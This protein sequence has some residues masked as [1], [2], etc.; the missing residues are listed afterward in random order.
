L[1]DRDDFIELLL[2]YYSNLE[3]EYQSIVPLKTVYV[4][5]EGA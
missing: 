2:E 3:S 4:P 5:T 1:L